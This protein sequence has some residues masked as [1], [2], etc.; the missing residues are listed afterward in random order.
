M[1]GHAPRMRASVLRALP[2]L[3][4]SSSEKAE[5]RTPADP[6]VVSPR[7]TGVAH[8]FWVGS[9]SQRRSERTDFLLIPPLFAPLL[10]RTGP[11]LSLGLVGPRDWPGPRESAS[12]VRRPRRATEWAVTAAFPQRPRARRWRPRTG[13]ISGD[14]R[15]GGSGGLGKTVWPLETGARPISRSRRAERRGSA[16]RAS[17]EP[18]SA[19]RVGSEG[20]WEGPGGRG[21][22][23]GRAWP[24]GE[25]AAGEGRRGGRPWPPWQGRGPGWGAALGR[26]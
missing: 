20:S 6:G 9:R 21:L 17:F 13:L 11:E 8:A 26:V 18:A 16:A 1:P 5:T 7:P 14:P 25:A 22:R 12:E 3:I 4:Q 15:R 2:T 23:L 10:P 24:R 19:G